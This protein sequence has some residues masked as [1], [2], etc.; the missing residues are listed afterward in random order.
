MKG[1]LFLCVTILISTLMASF[2]YSWS[3]K[4]EIKIWKDGAYLIVNKWTGRHCIF[5]P[6]FEVQ[7]KSYDS[8]IELCE[9]E[10]GKIKLP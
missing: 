3:N 2:F 7:S 4:V 5:H 10:L 8:L 6:D 9:G 1:L